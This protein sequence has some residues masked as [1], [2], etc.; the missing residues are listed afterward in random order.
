MKH[1]LRHAAWIIAGAAAAFLLILTPAGKTDAEAAV[2]GIDVSAYQGT[3]NWSAVAG[4]GVKFAMVRVGNTKYGLDSM[5]ATNVVGANAAGIRVGAYVYSYART[6]AEAAADAQ[7]A[8]TACANLPVSFPIAIDIEDNS[9]ADL[10]AA[11]QQAI[12]NTFC[13]TV[14]AAGYQPMVYSYRNWFQTKLG[15]TAW[16]HWVAD[17]ASS[18]GFPGTMWQYT[19]SGAVAGI[20]GN[21]DMDYVLKDYFT[22]IP[23]NGLSTQN[24]VTY[25]FVNFR[26]Q[27]GMQNVNGVVYFFDGTGA[28]VKNQTVTDGANNIIRMCNDGHVVIIT[29]EAQV[30]AAQALAFYNQQMALL[31]QDQAA[32]TAAEQQAAASGAQYAALQAQADQAAATLNAAA[33]QYAAAPT[34][35]ALAVFAAAQAQSDQAAAAAATALT[36]YQQLTVAAQTAAQTT[37]AQTAIAAQAKATSDAAQA[38]IVVPQ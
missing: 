1:I 23:A 38:A 4:S 8:V 12:V 27:F 25:Y 36:Q 31:A 6:T 20:S 21:V 29:A 11:Q 2:A 19:S 30:A 26:K 10:T 35:D 17:Y 7:L 37:T 14:Y 18:M 3:I 32:Q 22:T 28:M 9:Q 34:Q 16:D 24:G 33:A 15:A 5:F 13:A